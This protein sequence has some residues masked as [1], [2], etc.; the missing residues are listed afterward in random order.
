[1]SLSLFPAFFDHPA[2]MRFL[3][4]DP[5]E[6]IEILVRQHWVVNV[7][8]VVTAIIGLLIPLFI[9]K[10]I[11][12]LALSFNLAMVVP[13]NVQA[14]LLILWYL[15]ILAYVLE[16]YLFWYFNIYIVTNEHLS[17]ISFVNLL[18]RNTTEVLLEDV[19]SANT[20][21]KG[22][23]RSLFNF[24]DVRVETAAERQQIYFAAIPHPDLVANRIQELQE[25]AQGGHHSDVS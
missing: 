17:D 16:A 12:L 19:Q 1:M 18:N 15:L 24:G 7:P 9:P 22:F 21:M 8:W 6:H 5:D 4:Q 23:L 14:T 10:V 3:D 11:P 20:S 25:N 2:R 13:N